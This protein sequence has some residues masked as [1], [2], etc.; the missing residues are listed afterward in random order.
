MITRTQK[1]LRLVETVLTNRPCIALPAPA[2][3]GA[4]SKSMFKDS[5]CRSRWSDSSSLTPKRKCTN[6]LISAFGTTA[7]CLLTDIQL[8]VE[9]IITTQRYVTIMTT[10]ALDNRTP[11]HAH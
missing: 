4:P 8:V 5:K 6:L 10:H 3:F 2:Q 9:N 1:K 11:M 7:Y